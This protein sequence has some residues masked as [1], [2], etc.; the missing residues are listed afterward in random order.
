MRPV[1][2]IPLALFM[3]LLCVLLVK[4][5][6]SSPEKSVQALS[7]PQA[8][9][10]KPVPDFSLESVF[11]SQGALVRKDLEGEFSLV[12]IFASWCVACMQE[13]PHLLA[14][15]KSGRLPVY[16][17]NWRD[18]KQEVLEWLRTLG[19]PYTKIGWDYNGET[20]IAFGITGAPES[21]L[22]NPE[23]E[24]IYRHAGPLDMEIVEKEILSRLKK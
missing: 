14:L 12:N 18:K 24:V 10:G 17:I 7:D 13:H 6:Q 8:I 2:F 5:Y 4:L 21:F 20:A 22:I 3:I 1:L 11:V 15:K 16:G 23:G 9:V 19:N